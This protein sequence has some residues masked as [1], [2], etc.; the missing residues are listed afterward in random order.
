MPDGCILSY[1][2]NKK[3]TN[4]FQL[5]DENVNEDKNWKRSEADNVKHPISFIKRKIEFTFFIS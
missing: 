2:I 1:I 4:Q 5:M 3:E